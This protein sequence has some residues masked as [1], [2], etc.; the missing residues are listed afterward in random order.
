MLT[1]AH[2]CVRGVCVVVVCC[3]VVRVVSVL[4]VSGVLHVEFVRQLIRC[5]ARCVPLIVAVYLEILY[6]PVGTYCRSGAGLN[7]RVVL[8][9]LSTC[10]GCKRELGQRYHR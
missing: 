5:E 1:S 3:G 7:L 9:V 10:A 2:A 8:F 4:C 6:V